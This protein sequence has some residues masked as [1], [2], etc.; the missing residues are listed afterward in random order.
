VGEWVIAVG[1]PLGIEQTVTAGI[2]SGKG[3]AGRMGGAD[4]VSG[5]IQTDAKINPGN[6]GGPLVNLDGEVVGINTW[7]NVGPGGAYGYAIPINDVRRVSDLIVREGRVRYAY[8]G[9][10]VFDAGKPPAERKDSLPADLPS[11]GAVVDQ[12]A[13]GSPAAKAALRPGD[14]ITR[15]DA[16]PIRTAS[17]VVAYVSSRR[18]GDRVTVAYLRGGKGGSAAVV[19]G[20]LP[21]SDDAIAAQSGKIGLQLQTLTP[22]LAQSLG[23]PGGTRGVAIADVA[24]GSPAERAGLQAGEA[25]V[26]VDRKPVATADE[27]VTALRQ[28]GAHLLRVRGPSG[29]RFVTVRAE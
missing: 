20:E 19:L 11:E 22:D 6:S 8:L 14:V 29:S 26:E 27:A 17:D 1:S 16:Q 12:V 7:I 9:V 21:S 25:I 23:L 18:I 24:P 15:I 10:T 13:S 3:R 28:P 2:V 4:R 5:W